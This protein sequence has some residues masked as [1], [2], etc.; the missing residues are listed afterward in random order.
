MTEL[1]YCQIKIIQQAIDFTLNQSLKMLNLTEIKVLTSN[2]LTDTGEWKVHQKSSECKHK[3][4]IPT[5]QTHMSDVRYH[6]CSFLQCTDINQQ[7]TLGANVTVTR[8][9]AVQL[10]VCMFELY[11]C[12]C[13]NTGINV[14]T[15]NLR[16]DKVDSGGC[17]VVEVIKVWRD[18]AHPWNIKIH[19]TLGRR[20]RQQQLLQQQHLD[21][22]LNF[23]PSTQAQIDQQ[24]QS[25]IT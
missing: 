9:I 2:V 24:S 4:Q 11:L 19:A 14:T 10:V 20:Q 12:Q 6:L 8:L 1:Y 17:T 13:L 7:D 22:V 21:F 15:G 23:H 18:R 5:L 16:D 3:F 25:V